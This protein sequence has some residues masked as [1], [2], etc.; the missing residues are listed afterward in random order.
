MPAAPALPFL[1]PQLDRRVLAVAP[2][3]LPLWL[4]N[5]GIR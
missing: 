4:G 2:S 3:L 5:S 1:P